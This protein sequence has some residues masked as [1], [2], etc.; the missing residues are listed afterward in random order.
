MEDKF[1]LFL[2]SSLCVE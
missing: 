1:F 2:V